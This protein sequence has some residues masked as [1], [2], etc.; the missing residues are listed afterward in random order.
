MRPAT[1][2][3][4]NTCNEYILLYVDDALA[5]GVDAEKILREELGKYFEL[6]EESIG[7][8]A[9]YLGGKLSLVQLNN[10]MEAWSISLSQYVQAAVK[11]VEKHLLEKSSNLPKR[12]ETPMTTSYCPELDVSEELG[13]EEALYYMSLIG[14]LRWMVELG[15]V[16]ICLEVSLLSS[17]LALPRRGSL[18]TLRVITMQNLF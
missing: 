11:N 4:G 10:G 9:L 8:P 1:M 12:C 2:P 16:D 15:R 3:D 18:A 13:P 5:I 17:H 7:P 14:I 6:K